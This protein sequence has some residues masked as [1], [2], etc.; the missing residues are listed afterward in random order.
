M[1][2]PVLFTDLYELTMAYGY[3]KEGM[4]S[5]DANF[6]LFFRK[7][8][9]GGSYAIVAGL[10][11]ALDLLERWKLSSA[12]AAYLSSLQDSAGKPLFDP[13]FITYLSQLRLSVE[14][15]SMPEGALVFPFEPLLRVQGPIIQCQL[16]ESLLLNQINYPTLIATKAARICQAAQGDPVVEFGLRRAQGADGALSASRAAFIGGCTA[17][18]NVWAG[19]RFGIPVSGTQAHSWVMAFED[20]HE[21]F[22]A[23]HRTLPRDAVFLVDTYNT[24]HG[25]AKAIEVAQELQL[26][27]EQWSAIRLDSGDPLKLSREARRLLDAAG[28]QHVQ[29]VASNELNETVIESLKSKGAPINKWGVGTHLVT[30]RPQAALDGVYKLTALRRP[31][32]PWSNRLKLSEEDTKVS[33]PGLHQVRRYADGDLIYDISQPPGNPPSGV[34]IQ[35]QPKQLSGPGKDLLEPVFANGQRKHSTLPLQLLQSRTRE[36][37]THLTPAQKQLEN[38]EPYWVGLEEQLN[39]RREILVK[40]QRSQP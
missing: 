15:H 33:Y 5:W 26:T 37:L 27:P 30:G 40:Q 22:R 36:S 21:A 24:L 10:D 3:W 13:A 39:S 6:Y 16:L 9:F 4:D 19:Q 28:Y 29:I 12:D 34:S 2:P 35:G 7:P 14:V 11:P 25:V 8:P 1:I 38:P 32:Q 31:G 23:F 20:E 17:T 18:S